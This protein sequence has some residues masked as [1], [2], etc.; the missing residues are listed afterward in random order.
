MIK[1]AWDHFEEYI[2]IGSFFF[3]VPLVFFQVIMRYVFDSSLGWSEEL[4][5]YVFLW[6]IWLGASYAAKQSRHIRIEML[7]DILPPKAK[8]ALEIMVILIWMFFMGFL[9]I[10]GGQMTRKILTL[11]QK[12]SAMR[13]PMGWAYLS[14]PAGSGLM[15]IRLAEK[16]AEAIRAPLE[17]NKDRNLEMKKAMDELGLKDE[18]LPE[19]VE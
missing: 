4:A 13:I 10:K 7:K 9:A 12:S 1:K 6:Q 3:S 11:G 2:L 15:F 17:T 8:K 18:N 16:L 14:V 19:E 5:R